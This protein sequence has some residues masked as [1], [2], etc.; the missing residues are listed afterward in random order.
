MHAVPD[1]QEDEEDRELYPGGHSAAELAGVKVRSRAQQCVAGFVWGLERRLCGGVC[2]AGWRVVQ[3][4]RLGC[5]A[6]QRKLE[7]GGS[8]YRAPG[9][10]RASAPG[11]P[12]LYDIYIVTLFLDTMHKA[13]G[14]AGESVA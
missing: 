14:E 13:V 6:G 12:A 4:V 5:W 1:T 11:D 7:V 9:D 3:E 8:L 10:E 2:V